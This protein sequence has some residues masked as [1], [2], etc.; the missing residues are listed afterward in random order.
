MSWYSELGAGV[1]EEAAV[2]EQGVGADDHAFPALEADNGAA[3]HVGVGH[4]LDGVAFAHA[5]L[6]YF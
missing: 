4:V 3:H 1:T 2:G 5:I 6:N